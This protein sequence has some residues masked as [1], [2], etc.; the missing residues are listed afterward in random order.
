MVCV[1]GCKKK[2]FA[3]KGTILPNEDKSEL[4]QDLCKKHYDELLTIID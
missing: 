3:K 2:I 1:G 4:M